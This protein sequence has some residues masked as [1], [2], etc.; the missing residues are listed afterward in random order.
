MATIG[1]E[2]RARL[3][4]EG[5]DKGKCVCYWMSRDQRAKDNSSLALA[6]Q[7]ANK[8]DLPVLSFFCLAPTFL[9]ATERHY[10]FM[11]KGL[12]ETE[13]DLT[14]LGIGFHLLMG[15]PSSAVLE[16]LAKIEPAVMVTDFDPL[17]SKRRW[18][19]EVRQG[20]KVTIYEVDSHNI[21]PCWLASN[22]REWAAATFRLKVRRLLPVFL[23]ELGPTKRPR[24]PWREFVRTDWR[25]AL[26]SLHVEE[27]GPELNW[28]VPGP[29]AASDALKNLIVSRL[30]GYAERRND[31]TIEGQS[32]LSPF[33]HFG[34]ISPHRVAW[35]I[36]NADASTE[37]KEAF[38]EELTV[39][40]EL[41]DNFCLNTPDYD[42]FGSFPEWARTSLD[43]HRS[44]KRD[45]VYSLR[46]FE[47]A[48]TH[49]PLWNA[50]QRE[51]VVRGKMHGYLRMYWAK[52]VL[53]W[54]ESPEDALRTAVHLNDSYELDGRDPNGYAGIA[55]SIGG[56]HDRAWPPRKVFGKVRFMS[57][58][59]AKSK[60][61]VAAYIAK[62]T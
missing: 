16:Y 25:V 15:E 61:D 22:K 58:S 38:L 35:E 11:L 44:D 50:A 48:R 1:P 43:Q 3:V 14:R 23:P 37:S 20:T 49:D 54:S 27:R 8:L 19:E 36:T 40:R 2:G 47:E 6:V 57:Y 33:L 28:I 21:I 10:A 55:W 17:R 5:D 12:Q 39:R 42:S 30:E 4:Q 7:K 29:K 34:Q 52:K 18:I 51:M 41:S 45:Y 46:E 31:P 24:L 26:A 59:G 13:K 56:V 9:G 53:E 62:W 32:D 60:F